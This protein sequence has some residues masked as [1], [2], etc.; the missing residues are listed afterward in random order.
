MH[1]PQ[2]DDSVNTPSSSQHGK[3][4]FFFRIGHSQTQR[5]NVSIPFRSDIHQIIN[6][7]HMQGF[8]L[9]RLREV[10]SGAE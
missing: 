3:F 4:L 9:Y 1:S 8:A 6:F 2:F 10:R 5:L 7:Q